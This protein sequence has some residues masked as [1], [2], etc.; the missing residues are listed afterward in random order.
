VLFTNTVSDIYAFRPES[1]NTPDW[2]QSTIRAGMISENA[3]LPGQAYVG[4]AQSRNS[5]VIWRDET[6]ALPRQHWL[7]LF[8]PD[9]AQA[10][11]AELTPGQLGPAAL[12]DDGTVYV[13]D[14]R[15]S[16]FAVTRSGDIKWKYETDGLVQG[17]AVVGSDGTIYF[18]TPNSVHALAPDGT[19]K[20]KVK[21]PQ[22]NTTA[23]TLAD[24]GTVYVGGYFGF[25]ALHS[26]G[27]VKWNTRIMSPT[28]P[29]TIAPNGTI[30]LPCGY[31]WVCAMQDDGSPLAKSPW[32]KMYHD[33]ANTGRI[34][35][36]F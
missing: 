23:P 31:S 26:D 29:A 4:Q 18:A 15:T 32:P 5:P 1:S 20:W 25:L 19:V 13:A 30:Y 21:S 36:S 7:H 12:A 16:F 10:W 11:L 2:S 9:G 35:T 6:I 24:D 17:S 22:Q 28:G 34:L 8:N 14:D 3:S 27:S 33:P